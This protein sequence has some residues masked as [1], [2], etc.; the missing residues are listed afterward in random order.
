MAINVGSKAPDFTL[1]NSDKKQV[2]L[3]D[4]AGKKLIINFFPAAFT[5]V[6]TEQL[7]SNNNALNVYNSANAAVVGVSVDM[8]F[9]LGVFK[10]QQKIDFDLLSDFNKTMVKDYD[11]YL[12]DFAFGMKGVAKRGV[13]VIDENGTVIHSEETANPSVQID[14]DAL[15]NA[16]KN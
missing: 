13:V 11:F 3:S 2:S 12:E 16:L 6:C 14:F 8:P 5:G 15:N 4:F 7:C 9:S 1:T 10:E